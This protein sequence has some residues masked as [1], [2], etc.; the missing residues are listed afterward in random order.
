MFAPTPLV[1][2]EV[3]VLPVFTAARFESPG[4]EP[5]SI[6]YAVAAQPPFGPVHVSVIDAP[7]TV[8]TS[9]LGGFG[10]VVHADGPGLPPTVT[11][12]SLEAGL[13]PV[14]LRARTRT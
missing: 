8:A 12:T 11:V 7:F 13:D 1:L 14:R 2:N 3:P 10:A 6:T 9:P 4:L 5:A